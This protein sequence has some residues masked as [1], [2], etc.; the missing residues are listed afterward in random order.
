M[1]LTKQQMSQ[2]SAADMAAIER[3]EARLLY[4]TFCLVENKKEWFK[5]IYASMSKKYGSAYMERVRGYMTLEREKDE[6]AKQLQATQSD[7][8]HDGMGQS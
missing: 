6:K 8:Q 4:N 2:Q 1:K 5:R 7:C 3:G